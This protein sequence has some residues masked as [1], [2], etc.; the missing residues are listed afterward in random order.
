MK[1]LRPPDE[2]SSSLFFANFTLFWAKEL[3]PVPLIATHRG[4]LLRKSINQSMCGTAVSSLD[5]FTYTNYVNGSQLLFRTNTS[6]KSMKRMP[7]VSNKYSIYSL[8]CGKMWDCLFEE[9]PI[10][11]QIYIK[12]HRFL[13]ILCAQ[14]IPIDYGGPI[15]LHIGPPS[16]ASANSVSFAVS[17]PCNKPLRPLESLACVGQSPSAFVSCSV[18]G[19]DKNIRPLQ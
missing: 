16:G 2:Q 18:N 4:T 14:S 13:Y 15:L 12:C 9:W 17:I 10:L 6:Q 8:C 7:S 11:T 19:L 3:T 1:H 5:Q